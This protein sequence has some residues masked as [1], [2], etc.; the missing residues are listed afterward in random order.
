[1][2]GCLF[3]YCGGGSWLLCRESIL[4]TVALAFTFSCSAWMGKTMCFCSDLFMYDRLMCYMMLF[5][6]CMV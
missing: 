2:Y 3:G 5:P 1:M 6:L 4:P